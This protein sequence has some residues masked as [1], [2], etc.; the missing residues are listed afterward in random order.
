MGASSPLSAPHGERPSGISLRQRKKDGRRAAILAAARTIF[1]E[2][3]YEA[4][5]IAEVARLAGVADGTIYRHFANKKDLLYQV[6]Q[7]FHEAVIADMEAEVRS[8]EDFAGRLYRLIRHHLAVF[9]E[10]ADLCRLFIREVRTAD[11]YYNS[12]VHGLN[13]RYTSILLVIL[14]QGL[15]SGEVSAEVNPKVVRDL[16][17][18]TIEHLAWRMAN[19]GRALRMDAAARQLCY[20]VLNGIGSTRTSRAG[21]E[22]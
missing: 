15:A 13:R 18:G 3:G 6:M 7:T 21:R 8:A 11:D 10:D 2:K 5:A 9:I 17:Y 16:V 20:I 14:K 1:S 12:L 19:G 4:A 22:R